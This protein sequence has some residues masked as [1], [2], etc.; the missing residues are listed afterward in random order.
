MKAET[1]RKRGKNYELCTQW[2]QKNKKRFIRTEIINNS[3]NTGIAGNCNRGYKLARG[4]WIKSIAGDDILLHT[5]IENNLKYTNKNK[6]ASIIFSK[7]E[8]FANNNSDNKIYPTKEQ[9]KFYSLTTN[10]QLEVILHYNQPYAPTIFI[11]RELIEKINYFDDNIQ[12]LEDWPIYIK[13]LKLGYHIDY[14]SEITVKYRIEES[15]TRRKEEIIS[16]RYY[17]SLKIFYQKYLFPIYRENK[18]YTSLI[19]KKIWLIQYNL[20]LT[21]LKNRKSKIS[22]YILRLFDFIKPETYL[23]KIQKNR[24]KYKFSY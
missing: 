10:E 24:L 19:S 8:T 11:K 3:Y 17:N 1:D 16:P 22:Y 20:V 9:E 21:I 4:K 7:I 23:K 6:N 18:D 2:I 13:I 14:F 12:F 5:C 15:I